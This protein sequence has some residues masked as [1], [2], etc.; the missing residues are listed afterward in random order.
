MKK[1]VSIVVSIGMAS[2]FAAYYF[3]MR[4]CRMQK[5]VVAYNAQHLQ[6][7][8]CVRCYLEWT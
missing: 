7:A 6:Y 3:L 5:V 2:G 4:V 1:N 8:S